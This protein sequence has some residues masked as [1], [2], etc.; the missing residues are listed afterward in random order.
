MHITILCYCIFRFKYFNSDNQ[1]TAKLDIPTR[2]F[3]PM[4]LKP[5]ALHFQVLACEI[6]FCRED[7]YTLLEESGSTFILKGL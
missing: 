1:V 7:R 4:Q 2:D 6:A 5:P 3:H